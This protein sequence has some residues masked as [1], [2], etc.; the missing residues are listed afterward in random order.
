[1][2]NFQ[3]YEY[4]NNWGQYADIEKQISNSNSNIKYSKIHVKILETIKEENIINLVSIQTE[5]N[6]YTSSSIRND[7]NHNSSIN[8]NSSVRNNP[9]YNSSSINYN[10][11]IFIMCI[12]VTTQLI[13]VL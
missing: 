3:K 8:Y 9:N 10:I 1:M 4:N 13:Y 11:C 6:Q 2:A 12:Y 5:K 7:L